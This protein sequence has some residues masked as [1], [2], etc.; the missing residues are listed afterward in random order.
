MICPCRIL[1]LLKNTSQTIMDPNLRQKM[2]CQLCGETFAHPWTL[3]WHM[4]G[5][6]TNVRWFLCDFCEHTS[7]YHAN[8]MKHKK[9]NHVKEATL[10]GD[11]VKSSFLCSLC[12]MRF[13][14]QSDF[15]RHITQEHP[16]ESD[17]SVK[18]VREGINDKEKKHA[19]KLCSKTFGIRDSL[20]WHMLA[21]HTQVNNLLN[22]NIDNHDISLHFLDRSGG[23]NVTFVTAIGSTTP[24][25]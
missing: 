4:L 2:G 16:L 18:P 19:C 14:S 23:F 22:S 17:P 7:T 24:T 3:R 11:D 6:H 8:I 10:Y 12:H 5:I 25:C 1:K 15:Y 13:M 9:A 20:K 21:T